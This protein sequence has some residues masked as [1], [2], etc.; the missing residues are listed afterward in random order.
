MSPQASENGSFDPRADLALAHQI[1]QLALGTEGVA[2]ISGGRRAEA[3]T[4]WL[5]EKVVG[6]AVNQANVE[7]HVVARY[8]GGFPI[9][10][11]AERLRS[12]LEPLAVGRRLDV[13]VD[14]LVMAEDDAAG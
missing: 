6:V 7:V 5:G 11:L 8:P 1:K 9:P 3:A 2:T 4:R 13:V 12:T 10:E 14:D